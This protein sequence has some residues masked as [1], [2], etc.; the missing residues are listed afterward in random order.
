VHPYTTTTTSSSNTTATTTTSRPR[1][2]FL[3]ARG[4]VRQRGRQY[5][6]F[7]LVMIAEIQLYMISAA[8]YF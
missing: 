8:I 7:I 3:C 4:G 2:L 5:F 6:Q 1:S